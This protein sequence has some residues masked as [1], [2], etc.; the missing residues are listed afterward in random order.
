MRHTLQP[1]A[2]LTCL[3]LNASERKLKGLVGVP[4]DKNNNNLYFEQLINGVYRQLGWC[5]CSVMIANTSVV[6]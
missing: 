2:P 5:A 1:A 3:Q 4:I 6:L